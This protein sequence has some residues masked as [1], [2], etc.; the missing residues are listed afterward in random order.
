MRRR[1]RAE[2][3]DPVLALAALGLYLLAA[4][5]PWVRAMVEPAPGA[6]RSWAAVAPAEAVAWG[7]AAA[8]VSAVAVTVWLTARA[9]WRRWVVLSGM[10]GAGVAAAAATRVLLDPAATLASDVVTAGPTAWAWVAAASGALA[11][12]A[13]GRSLVSPT[14]APRP[15]L[16]ER[17][18]P[19]GSAAEIQRRSAAR[20][21][22]DLTEGRD[23]TSGA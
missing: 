19:D 16:P 11:C 2:V 17:D 14:A 20:Q 23:P 5:Q 1:R 7:P 13:L 18:T 10:L 6:P 15:V 22:Q 9:G 21:W 12:A 4:T 3:I 8:L